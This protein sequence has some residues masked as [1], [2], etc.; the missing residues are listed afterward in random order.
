MESTRSTSTRVTSP[1]P[2]TP[3]SGFQNSMISLTGNTPSVPHNVNADYLKNVM[4]QFLGQ[5]KKMQL[6]L[7]PV[8]SQLLQFNKYVFFLVFLSFDCFNFGF[9][10][11]MLM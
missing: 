4:L 6:Q 10:S 8:L 2:T 5:D 9:G 11:L 7:I 3:G 1:A